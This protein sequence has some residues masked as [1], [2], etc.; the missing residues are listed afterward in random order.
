MSW[1]SRSLH[2]PTGILKFYIEALIGFSNVHRPVMYTLLSQGCILRPALT[3]RMMG[4]MYI[5]R[6]EEGVRTSECVDPARRS[7]SGH[8]LSTFSSSR[9]GLGEQHTGWTSCIT[10]HRGQLAWPHPPHLGNNILSQ[11][12]VR[13]EITR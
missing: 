10:L 12:P 11:M 3:V 6:T 9:V 4:R 1:E 8:V 5:P 7:A 13:G 2:L